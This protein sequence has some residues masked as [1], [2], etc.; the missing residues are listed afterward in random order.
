MIR[1]KCYYS[2]SEG[3]LSGRGFGTG[4]DED[5]GEASSHVVTYPD[6]ERR[7]G[8]LNLEGFRSGA[9]GTS[10]PVF[11]KGPA[12]GEKVKSGF[13]VDKG[14]IGQRHVGF[15]VETWARNLYPPEFE[16]RILFPSHR[17]VEWIRYWRQT[18]NNNLL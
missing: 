15:L 11:T 2:V 12:K 3:Y 13:H 4:L 6:W 10:A 9:R 8:T 5:R 18:Q 16:E 14:L 17:R 1:G 7:R